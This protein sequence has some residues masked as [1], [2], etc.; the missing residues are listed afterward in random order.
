[1][2]HQNAHIR[3]LNQDLRQQNKHLELLDKVKT[4]FITI[5]S[6]ELR[7]PLT[8][9]KGYTDILQAMNE[10]QELGRAQIREILNH[11]NRASVRLETLISAMLDAS[12]LEVSGMELSF[13]QTRLETVVQLAVEPLAAAIRDR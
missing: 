3:L 10:E 13:T 6:H 12:Q 11:I 4:D 1:L 8:Q 5:A 7:T 9:V 2:N